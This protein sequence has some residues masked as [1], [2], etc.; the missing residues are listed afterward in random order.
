MIHTE[1]SDKPMKIP[2]F[3]HRAACPD[4]VPMTLIIMVHKR[5]PGIIEAGI[6]EALYF[7]LNIK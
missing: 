2:C 5:G 3:E 4:I 7:L 1:F 6:I